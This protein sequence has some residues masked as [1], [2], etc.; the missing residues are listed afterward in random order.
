RCPGQTARAS[1]RVDFAGTLRDNVL[2]PFED[3]GEP[4]EDGPPPELRPHPVHADP[5][6]GVAH[7]ERTAYAVHEPI[8]VERIDEDRAVNLFGGAGEAAEHEYAALLELTREKFLRHEFHSV[9]QRRDETEIRGAIHAREH[10]RTD[11]LMDQHD[12]RPLR[13][14]KARVD[15]VDPCD[16]F[17][18]ELA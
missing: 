7:L 10:L 14:A 11:V 2:A 18:F 4:V 13:R 16:H 15:L 9:L 3:G 5:A 1:R 6:L 8:D 12:G 17:L